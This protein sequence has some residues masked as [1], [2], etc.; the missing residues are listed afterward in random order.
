MKRSCVVLSLLCFSGACTTVAPSPPDARTDVTTPPTDIVD[1]IPV[2][3]DTSTSV[4][5][6]TPVD[7]PVPPDVQLPTDTGTC[8][9]PRMQCGDRCISVEA[10]RDNCGRCN[11][12]CVAPMGGLTECADGRCTGSCPAGRVLCGASCVDLQTDIDNCGACGYRV[13]AA[14]RTGEANQRACVAGKPSPAWVPV[15]M[16][17]PPPAARAPQIRAW[18]GRRLLVG[19]LANNA[20]LFLY[21]PDANSWTESAATTLSYGDGN[22]R[23]YVAMPD[24]NAVMVWAADGTRRDFGIIIRDSGAAINVANTPA[25]PMPLQP[26]SSPAL[27][28]DGTGVHVMFG[29]GS[30]NDNGGI[31]NMSTESWS[32]VPST[33]TPAC[34]ANAHGATPSAFARGRINAFGGYNGSTSTFDFCRAFDVFSYDVGSTAWLTP[35]NNAG[36]PFRLNHAWLSVGNNV[37]LVGGTDVANAN[38]NDAWLFNPTER[39]AAGWMRVADSPAPSPHT[40]RPFAMYTGRSVIIYSGSRGVTTTSVAGGSIGVISG[41]S[42]TWSPLPTSGAPSPRSSGSGEQDGST[43]GLWTGREAII[44]GGADGGNPRNDGARYQPPVGCVCPV[45]TDAPSWLPNACAGVTMVTSPA[46]SP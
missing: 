37:L 10:D 32:V 26:R 14:G 5:T 39:T 13:V 36:V 19:S 44:W 1:D 6:P 8:P 25:W 2:L 7:T 35:A 15:S 11:N 46:C 40:S 16:G 29:F 3:P 22:P 4:D 27:S 33:L 21:S 45:N 31:Y 43:Q 12:R 28:Y 38:L 23:S 18:T 9:S 41:T 20:S 42:I 30:N 24:R 34:G 17:S